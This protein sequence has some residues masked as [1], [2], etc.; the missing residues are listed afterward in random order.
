LYER[1]EQGM[2]I[3]RAR[4]RNLQLS[5]ERLSDLVSLAVQIRTFYAQ[6]N[7]IFN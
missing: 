1:L 7:K 3:V 4:F 6:E 5:K 2:S